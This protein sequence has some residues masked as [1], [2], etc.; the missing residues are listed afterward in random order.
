MGMWH[1]RNWDL[2]SFPEACVS[3]CIVL[4]VGKSRSGGRSPWLPLL[5]PWSRGS[6]L[7]LSLGAPGSP[8]ALATQAGFA[9]DLRQSCH[10]R[11]EAVVG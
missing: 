5:H 11:S 4:A 3:R 7:P 8:A 1:A 10:I 2:G 9:E 6:P